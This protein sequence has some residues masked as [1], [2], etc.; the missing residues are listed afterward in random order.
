MNRTSIR[1]WGIALL[2]I[3]STLSAATYQIDGAHSSAGFTVRHMMV[4]NVSG[5]FTKLSG[6]VDYDADNLAQSRIEVTIEAASVNT[7]NEGRDKHI[8]TADF[9][10]VENHPTITFRSKRVEK[11]GEGRLRVAGDLT[12]RGVTKEVVLDVEGPTP[13]I[14]QQS[15]FRM[16]ASATTRINRKDFGVNYHRSLDNGGVVVSDDVRITIDVE[17]VRKAAPVPT[18]E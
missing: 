17:L 3:S 8:R 2:L 7:R 9:F 16:G 12:L 13:E 18:S 10:D 15:T 4:S 14:Q 11:A 1:R 5:A 6:S